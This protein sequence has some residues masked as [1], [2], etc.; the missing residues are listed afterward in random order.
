MNAL[1]IYSA[2]IRT[3]SMSTPNGFPFERKPIEWSEVAENIGPLHK[4]HHADP[5]GS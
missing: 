3:L 4:T 5:G 1:T 2:S